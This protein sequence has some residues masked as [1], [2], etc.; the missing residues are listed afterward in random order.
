MREGDGGILVSALF[1]VLLFQ[2]LLYSTASLFDSLSLSLSLAFSMSVHPVP[3]DVTLSALDTYDETFDLIQ[4]AP[5][6]MSPR[7]ANEK[8]LPRSR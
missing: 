4:K 1:I 6:S 8:A 7:L 2:L 3:F 5:S